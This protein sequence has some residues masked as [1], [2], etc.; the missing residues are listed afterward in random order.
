MY[1]IVPVRVY[2]FVIKTKVKILDLFFTAEAAKWKNCDSKVKKCDLQNIIT[3]YMYKGYAK[4][5]PEVFRCLVVSGGVL[6]PLGTQVHT[7]LN[8]S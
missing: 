8:N 3:I 5:C 1:I 6:T 2:Y 7:S 4:R